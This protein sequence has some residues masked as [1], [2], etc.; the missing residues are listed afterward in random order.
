MPLTSPAT[1]SWQARALE[2]HAALASDPQAP[3]LSRLRP[4]VKDSWLR[5]LSLRP[6]PDRTAAPVCLGEDELARRRREHPLAAVLPVFERLLFEPVRGTGLLVAVGDEHGKLLW[7][8]GDGPARRRA[9]RM[10]F[11]PGADWSERAVG[12]SAPGTALAVGAGVQ[13]SG[14]EH[15][16]RHAHAFSCTAVPVRCPDTGRILG[17]VD[18]TGGEDAVA[19]HTLALLQASV[20]AAEAE[21]RVMRLSAARPAPTGAP[22]AASIPVLPGSG[23]P[24]PV[25]PPVHLRI[26]G[27]AQP[28]AGTA[29][30]TEL[31]LRHAEILALLAWH[32]HGLSSDGLVELLHPAPDRADTGTLRAEMVR[33][34]K[35]M[36]T[37]DPQLVPASRPYRLGAAVR[38]DAHAVLAAL[39]RGE[40]AAAL[41]AYRGPVLPRSEAPGIEAIRAR[42]AASLREAM[43]QDA[44]ADT[45]LAYLRLPEAEDDAEAWLTALRL[46]PPRSPRRAG[47]VA[48]LESLG[49]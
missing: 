13:I 19:A 22:G 12:T 48:H 37:L 47:I 32:P 38:T 26:T 34:R 4:L 39:D 14:A 7:V 6:D 16:S 21:L 2:A 30:G 24:V 29:G 28:T 17:V 15:F 9:E 20:A 35:A 46:L 18:L 33:L 27:Y 23:T 43:L 40:H 42:V 3:A 8:D 25:A 41:A 45:L 5:S 31:G 11:Q 36:S 10:A 49:R 44:D 1:R